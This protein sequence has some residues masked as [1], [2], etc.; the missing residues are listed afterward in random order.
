MNGVIDCGVQKRGSCLFYVD[1]LDEDAGGEV[2]M[3][4]FLK[5]LRLICGRIVE[6]MFV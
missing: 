2:K 3:G 1:V 6:Y 5:G 4:N